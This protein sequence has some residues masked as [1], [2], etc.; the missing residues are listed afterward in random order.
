MGSDIETQQ[1]KL[2]TRRAVLFAVLAL[3]VLVLLLYLAFRKVEPRDLLSVVSQTD[4]LVVAAAMGVGLLSHL[5]RARRWQLLLNTLER[6]TTLFSAFYAVMVGYF[7]NLLLPRA[8]EAVRCVVVSRRSHVKLE[9]SLGTVVTERLADVFVMLLLTLITVL[10]GLSTFGTFLRDEVF[11]PFW[12]RTSRGQF[13]AIAIALLAVAGVALALYWLVRSG[14]LPPRLRARVRRFFRG[15]AQGIDSLRRMNTKWQFL[16]FTVALWG[17]YW[18]MTYLV[19]LALPATR[20]LTFSVSL[21][22]LVV[23]TFGMFVPVQGGIGSFHLIVTLWLMAL[24]FSRTEGLA[25]ATLSHG[26][27]TVLLIVVPAALEA[28]RL[29]AKLA[30]RGQTKERKSD[31]KGKE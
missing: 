29:I 27:Q 6:P 30:R 18:L 11:S 3:P 19:C 15:L 20:S 5:I 14:I 24:G 28:Y 10:F 4:W 16:A 8:G 23:G 13:L 9:K 2:S 1:S 31:G 21:T 12:A 17:A 26:C 7:F 22:L 25:Y